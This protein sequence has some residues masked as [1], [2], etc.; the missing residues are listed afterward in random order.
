MD[1]PLGHFLINAP[2]AAEAEEERRTCALENISSRVLA[3]LPRTN[4]KRGQWP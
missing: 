2:A 3:P 4:P 1:K